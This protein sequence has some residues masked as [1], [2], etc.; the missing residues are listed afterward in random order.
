[1]F[2]QSRKN[3][4]AWIPAFLA[5]T[6]LTYST[7][8]ALGKAESFCITT[9]CELFKDITIQGYSLWWFGSAFFAFAMLLCLTG[10]RTIALA[11]ATLALFID[12]LLLIFMAFTAPCFACLIAALLIALIFYSLYRDTGAR[13]RRSS[14]LLTIWLFA[15]CPNI[16]GTLNE[17]LGVWAIAGPEKADM[18]VFFSPSCPVCLATIERFAVN[19]D[20]RIAFIPVA[21]SETDVESIA[22]I[23]NSMQEGT[24]FYVAFKRTTRPTEAPVS[25]SVP[26]ALRW[27]LFRNKARLG[28]LGATR[29]PVLVTSGVPRSLLDA[30]SFENGITP[31]QNSTPSMPQSPAFQ[32]T[33]PNIEQFAGCGGE[34]APPC[35]Q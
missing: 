24:S 5:L 20:A 15:F 16:F 6:G 18:Q 14:L 1:M 13:N 35:P 17:S 34:A 7:L 31:F 10:R 22:R 2:E 29:I 23:S 26:L 19:P 8:Q 33:M 25:T 21:E 32:P 30:P 28:A 11:I 27:D 3:R 12:I 4:V 9:G